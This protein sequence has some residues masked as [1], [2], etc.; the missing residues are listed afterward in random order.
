MCIRDSLPSDYLGGVFVTAAWIHNRLEFHR[1]IADGAS[2]RTEMTVII[3]GDDNFR[4]I[5]ITTA[6][7]GSLYMT[8]WVDKSYNV[9]G[10]GRVWRIRSRKPTAPLPLATISARSRLLHHDQNLRRRAAQ[11][12]AAGSPDDWQYLEDIARGYKDARVRV[13]AIIALDQIDRISD[14]L[15]N[16]LIQDEQQRVREVAVL[17]L[18]HI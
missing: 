9:H 1:L 7:D 11:E 2:F 13:D 6:P 16:L 5:S 14:D 12:L 3:Q 17:S 15:K 10:F 18:I 4:P 8:D